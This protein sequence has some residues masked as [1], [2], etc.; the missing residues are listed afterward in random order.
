MRG[1]LMMGWELIAAGPRLLVVE[2][3]AEAA[4]V[5]LGWQVWLVQPVPKPKSQTP[6]SKTPKTPLSLPQTY[7]FIN[8][9]ACFGVA[10]GY[11]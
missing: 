1:D 3:A 8:P 4:K 2:L 11:Q 5:G 6:Q 9:K 10:I 7:P